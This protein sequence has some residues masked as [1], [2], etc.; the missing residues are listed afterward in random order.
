MRRQTE[1]IQS[2]IPEEPK[3]KSKKSKHGTASGD[4]PFGEMDAL[5]RIVTEK[6]NKKHVLNYFR[7][8]IAQLVAAEDYT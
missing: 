6:P 2:N 1:I 4:A 8:R 7:D 3:K 5:T